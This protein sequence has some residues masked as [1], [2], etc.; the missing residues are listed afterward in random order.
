M[1]DEKGTTPE[2][3]EKSKAE[4][5]AEDPDRFA[6]RQSL[7]FSVERHPQY[8]VLGHM[9]NIAREGMTGNQALEEAMVVQ[10]FIERKLTHYIDALEINIKKRAEAVGIVG[11]NGK[12]P[13]GGIINAVRN[14]FKR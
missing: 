12:K 1:S 10:K 11:A 14:G 2:P 13:Q 5:F 4:L 3:I 6:D 8:K 9:M 7:L